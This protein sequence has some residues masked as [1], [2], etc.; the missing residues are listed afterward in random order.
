MK[1]M[2]VTACSALTLAACA[3]DWQPKE[4]C[5]LLEKSDGL[6]ATKVYE[7]SYTNGANWV[8]G[9]LP[10]SEQD[11]WVPSGLTIR[12]DAPDQYNYVFPGKSLTIEDGATL[13]ATAAKA[14]KTDY[15]RLFGGSKLTFS[16]VPAPVF[17]NVTIDSTEEKPVVVELQRSSGDKPWP[18]FNTWSSTP[19][20][21]T[22]VRWTAKPCNRVQWKNSNFTDYKGVFR[23]ER[24]AS[25]LKTQNHDATNDITSALMFANRLELGTRVVLNRSSATGSITGG[26]VSVESGAILRSKYVS[27]DFSFMVVTNKL[28]LGEGAVYDAIEYDG[29]GVNKYDL[30]FKLIRLIGNAARAENLPDFSTVEVRGVDGLGYNY[31]GAGE[32]L[33]VF[34]DLAVPGGKYYGFR[35]GRP[36]CGMV[37]VSSVENP[38]TND[39]CWADGAFPTGNQNAYVGQVKVDGKT[40]KPELVVGTNFPDSVTIPVG[41]LVVNGRILSMLIPEVTITNLFLL[42]GADLNASAQY[43][44]STSAPYRNGRRATW[45]RGDYLGVYGE[46]GALCRVAHNR[47]LAIDMPL[48]GDG[49]MRATISSGTS[50]PRGGI[51]FTQINTNFYGKFIVASDGNAWNGSTTD[52]KGV[53]SPIGNRLLFF[54]SDARNIGGDMSD[55]TF[56]GL[57]LRGDSILVGVNSLNFHQR[58][59][60]VY[61]QDRIRLVMNNES[62]NTLV[63]SNSVTYGGEMVFGNDFP[64]ANNAKVGKG[65]GTL[66]LGGAARFYDPENKVA[67]DTPSVSSNQ[68]TMLIGRLRPVAANALDGV[69]VKFGEESDGLELDWNASDEMKATGFYSVKELSA[70]TSER[71]DGKIPVRVINVPADAVGET[72]AVC[73]VPTAIAEATLAKFTYDRTGRQRG[74]FS[75][76]EEKDGNRTILLNLEIHGMW[77]IVR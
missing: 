38:F 30:T 68:L 16:S 49:P 6:I 73:T 9:N 51:E 2:I 12:A 64:N 11:C 7:S 3:Y 25:S 76:G 61:V 20:S 47:L 74:F 13:D 45:L 31:W 41:G 42:G 67:C 32:R 52:P 55:E 72:I 1:T 18:E 36:T 22:I 77:L 50:Y 24:T 15:L 63:I 66:V 69:A 65:G 57:T 4:N 60:G 39:T 37:A 17:P 29:A 71:A 28:E 19:E 21:W 14:P 43:W 33:G 54:A 40:I 58:N 56:D 5:L 62:D 53:Y 70:L 8:G 23:L 44:K 59:R 35:S 26:V 75:L 46:N 27:D 48:C 10:T 34:D